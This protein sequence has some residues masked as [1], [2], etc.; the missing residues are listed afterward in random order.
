MACGI[1][2][3]QPQ[4][5]L[6]PSAMEVQSLNH[7]IAREVPWEIL[8]LKEILMR[9]PSGALSDMMSNKGT[10]RSESRHNLRV[11]AVNRL[12]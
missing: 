1:L 4:I 11:W 10:S 12:I 5:K 7:W 2:V 9:F 3:P 8:D 6:T